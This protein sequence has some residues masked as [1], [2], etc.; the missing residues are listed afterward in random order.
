MNSDGDGRGA[1][2]QDLVK[3]N[4]R[5]TADGQY[6]ALASERNSS[7]EHCD[8]QAARR[9][10]RMEVWVT[11]SVRGRVAQAVGQPKIASGG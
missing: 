8:A 4:K 10:S 9:H 11:E 2:V 6:S 1:I 7:D 3:K 5:V